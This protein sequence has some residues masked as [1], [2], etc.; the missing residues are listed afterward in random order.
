MDKVAQQTVKVKI[1][2][3]SYFKVEWPPVST[4]KSWLSTAPAPLPWALCLWPPRLPPHHCPV[5]C[6]ARS[7]TGQGA[8]CQLISQLGT[9]PC[10]GRS[11]CIT[12]QHTFIGVHPSETLA[13][14][15]VPH[16]LGQFKQR[17]SGELSSRN[18]HS[19]VTH[20]IWQT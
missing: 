19:F 9:Q 18:E 4:R 12:Q 16:V 17:A 3:L 8:K 11:G 2:V 7:S 13:H 15:G 1:Q 6:P 5:P 10:W 20:L 14:S